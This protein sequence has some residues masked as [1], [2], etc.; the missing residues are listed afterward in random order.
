MWSHVSIN[1]DIMISHLSTCFDS[2]AVDS[3]FIWIIKNS[4]VLIQFEFPDQISSV[5]SRTTKTRFHH[6]WTLHVHLWWRQKIIYSMIFI[7]IN[8]NFIT[9]STYNKNNL[10]LL[11]L[12]S[13]L[14]SSHCSNPIRMA[15]DASEYSWNS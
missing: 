7:S 11:N 12:W 2:V 15:G 10:F 1:E 14:I 6:H 9:N 4:E 3:H 13:N 8:S 5:W